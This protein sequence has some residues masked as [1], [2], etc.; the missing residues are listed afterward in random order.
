MAE[1]KDVETEVTEA[2]KIWAEIKDFP[3]NVYAVAQ[4]VHQC[5]TKID[6]PGDELFAKLKSSAVL[7]ALETT[8]GKRFSVELA[9]KYII[10]RRAEDRDAKVQAAEKQMKKRKEE[11]YFQPKTYSPKK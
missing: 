9:D 5:I 7:P 6:L 10:I 2:D 3:I 8:L 1:K 11:A 4:Q